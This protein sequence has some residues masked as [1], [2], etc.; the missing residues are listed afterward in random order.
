[1]IISITDIIARILDANNG[2]NV[3]IAR[4]AAARAKPH[5]FFLIERIPPSI[6]NIERINKI[7]THTCKNVFIVSTSRSILEKYDSINVS[8]NIAILIAVKIANKPDI[9]NKIPAI[10]G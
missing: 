6:E 4:I 10:N 2:P 3:N 5:N 7:A 1:M 9:I 8:G